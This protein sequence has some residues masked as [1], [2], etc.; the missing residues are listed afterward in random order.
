MGVGIG[1]GSGTGGLN[2]GF[3]SKGMPVIGKL[4]D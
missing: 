4:S 3:V 1:S 2:A